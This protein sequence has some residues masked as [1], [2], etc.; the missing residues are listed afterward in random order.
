MCGCTLYLGSPNKNLDLGKCSTRLLGNVVENKKIRP[1]NQ[2]P[3]IIQED[4][5]QGFRSWLT[6]RCSGSRVGEARGCSGSRSLKFS[7][8][9]SLDQSHEQVPRSSPTDKSHEQAP[10][11]RVEGTTPPLVSTH[12]VEAIQQHS[13]VQR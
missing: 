9:Q 7:H 13:A 12:P 2:E 1:T 11:R 5:I 6:N 4:C 10:R 3:K 8:E